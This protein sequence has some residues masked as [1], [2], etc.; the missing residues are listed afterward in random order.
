MKIIAIVN[1]KGGV[2]KSTSAL[3]IAVG[4][5]KEGFKTLLIDF[6]PQGNITT[7]CGI[8]KI[9]LEYTVYDLMKKFDFPQYKHLSIDSVAIKKH[10]IDILPTNIRMS[11]I[12]TELGGYP[13]KENYLKDV[14]EEAS[15]DYV[16][17]DCPPSLSMLTDNALTAATDV[18]V[19]VKADY[20]SI[21]GIA[22]LLDQV[23]I[24]KRKL[25]KK[26]EVSG[27]FITMANKRTTLFKETHN[28]LKKYF[29]KEM[30][31]TFIR[32]SEE[33]NKA[34]GSGKPLLDFN[35]NCTASEDYKNLVKEII[36]RNK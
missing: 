33:V 12:E 23:D 28:N 4:L 11:K 5:Q 3:N 31:E 36:E 15:Y 9:E 14:L 13:G 6:D 20:Y 34:P 35:S 30:F 25:N 21:E 32:S 26:L 16:I 24:I 8:D 29:M 27:V 2:A 1:Q 19:P 22:D 10:G 18:F 17:I 7:G